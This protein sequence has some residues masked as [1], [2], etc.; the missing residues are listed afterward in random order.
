MIEAGTGAVILGI[1]AVLGTLSPRPDEQAKS[2]HRYD[3]AKQFNA[4]V[5]QATVGHDLDVGAFGREYWSPR[6]D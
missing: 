3:N 5:T 2:R 1:V 6:H 4:Q